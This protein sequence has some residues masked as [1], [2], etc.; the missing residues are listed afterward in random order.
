MAYIHKFVNMW[1]EYVITREIT[2]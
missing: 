1:L 2:S